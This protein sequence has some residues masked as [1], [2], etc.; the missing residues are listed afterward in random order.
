MGGLVIRRTLLGYSAAGASRLVL[1]VSL[2]ICCAFVGGIYS[3]SDVLLFRPLVAAEPD[4]ILYILGLARPSDFDAVQW[5]SQC[6][7]VS[8]L[9]AFR[10]G[11]TAMVDSSDATPVRATMTAG[12]FFG[13]FGIDPAQGRFFTHEELSSPNA[14]AAVISLG[15]W[16]GHFGG[17]P[18][19]GRQLVIGGAPVYI[20]G[21]APAGF[22]FPARTQI[23]L[24]AKSIS[25]ESIPVLSASTDGPLVHRE[26]WVGKLAHGVTIEQARAEFGALLVRLREVY[27]SKTGINVGSSV[28][29][30][31]LRAALGRNVQTATRAMLAGAMALVLICTMNAAILFLYESLQRT[32]EFAT[33]MTVGAT[34]WKLVRQR[35]LE[36]ARTV[37][38][39]GIV[40]YVLW[41]AWVA[42]SRTFLSVA[43][44]T[45]ESRYMAG[46]H[47]FA[48]C[49]V[50]AFVSAVIAALPT[51]FHLTKGDLFGALKEY[52]PQTAGTRRQGIQRLLVAGQV[53][54]AI[55][56]AGSATLAF[57]SLFNM[58]K[59]TDRLGAGELLVSRIGLK[60][61]SAPAAVNAS[62]YEEV[63][64]SVSAIPGV[65][66]AAG[67]AS[68]FPG[69]GS[70]LWVSV[71]STTRVFAQQLLVTDDFFRTLRIQLT[72]GQ[73]F[74]R[75][76][77][78]VI[79]DT[80]LA[81]E[82][83]GDRSPLA[84]ELTID[85]EDVSRRVLGVVAGGEFLDREE[86]PPRIYLPISAPYRHIPVQQIDIAVRASGDVRPIASHL[87]QV[88]ANDNRI[89]FTGKGI[90]TLEAR[91]D[92]IVLP[93]R[94]RAIILTSLASIGILL[95]VMGVFGVA[96]RRAHS[97]TH[98]MA[99]RMVH[100]ATSSQIVWLVVAD[101]MEMVIA[102]VIFGVALSYAAARFMRSLLFGVSELDALSLTA[103]AL[104]LI[105]AGAAAAAIPAIST[106]RVNIRD[107]LS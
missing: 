48:V 28:S 86:S 73:T 24:A 85:G 64:E 92:N 41:L 78:G 11:E 38:G 81:R 105:V 47:V 83:W 66:A 4:R 80:N 54:L 82:L 101:A 20:V 17:R 98:E 63:I 74:T 93:D 37:V 34:V 99:I 76:T 65:Q 43:L 8:A 13:S 31:P 102:G 103:G 68:I 79:I 36:I 69:R 58:T 42:A 72:H 33:R 77:S 50:T 100:G 59:V 32:R 14:R 5:W 88:L 2:A 91:I 84:G 90:E 60:T 75:G 95:A 16:R 71:G 15:L 19:L 107:A 97:R 94:I 56:L 9:A 7:A 67:A 27:T 87:Y 46:M 106:S 49:L 3:I 18:V 25:S 55:A 29:V 35:C 23:W 51:G 44:P 104:L 1:F 39:A 89:Q 45:A 57:R 40:G 10:A 70:G 26:G 53:A 12:D 61:T 52:Q 6:R 96:S 30:R 21:V 22:S 62:Q